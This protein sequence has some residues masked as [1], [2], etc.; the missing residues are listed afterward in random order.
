MVHTNWRKIYY[1]YIPYKEIC[2]DKWQ[3]NTNEH[4]GYCSIWQ[5]YSGLN[6]INADGY[7]Y[8]KSSIF[9]TV[10]SRSTLIF[11]DYGQHNVRFKKKI[12]V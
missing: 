12:Q 2:M 8:N 6:V 11:N 1:T 10:G 7:T 4:L 9:S 5:T 3:N